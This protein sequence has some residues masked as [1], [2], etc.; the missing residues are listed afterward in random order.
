MVTTE[1]LRLTSVWE[2]NTKRV[3]FSGVPLTKNSYR[4]RSSRAVV[5]VRTNPEN[6]PMQPTVGQH[7]RITGNKEDREVEHGNYI[8]TEYHF[9]NPKRCEVTLP[10]N[11]ED[12]I[13]FISKETAFKGIGEVKARMLWSQ[14]GD[15]IF[16][17]LNNKDSDTLRSILTTEATLSLIE[18][19]EKY[20]NLRY[21]TWFSDHQI[22]PQIQQRLFKFHGTKAVDT[23]KENPYRLI[24]FGLNFEKTDQ[25]AQKH[26]SISR[27][28]KCRLVAAVEYSLQLHCQRGGHTL[29]HHKD[30]APRVRKLLGTAETAKKAF[31]L[32]QSSQVLKLNKKDGV[33]HHT[34]L[35][36]MEKVVAKRLVTL[37][38]QK[39]DWTFDY[40]LAIKKAIDDLPYLLMPKQKQAVSNSLLYSVACITGGA[41]TGKTTVLR[42]VLRAYN[43][44]GYDIRA[45]ALSGRAA[46]HLHK[47]IGFRTSTIARFLADA[48]IEHETKTIVVID[49]ASMIDLAT[50]FRIVN[51]IDPSVRLL[52]VGDHNQLPP[53]GPGLIL[54]DMVK[55]GLIPNVELDIVKRQDATTGI[56]E[57]SR[58]IQQ[59]EIPSQ[60]STGRIH[61]HDVESK[62]VAITCSKLYENNPNHSQVIAATRA[63]SSEIN[64]LCQSAINEDGESL[65]FTEFGNRYITDLKCFDPVL[66]CKNNY[67]AGVQ[68]GSLGTLAS[69]KQTDK[70]FGVVRINDSG[71]DIELTKMLLDSLLLGYA[72]TLHKAQGSQF[73]RVIVALSETSMIDRAWL[74]TAITR[75]E[76][77]LHL[78]GPTY[79]AHKAIKSLSAHHIRKTYLAR[80]LIELAPSSCYNA[81]M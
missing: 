40:E 35:L 64:T 57:Y 9:V 1:D 12:F 55:S 41:G 69:V 56:P 28:D 59:G 72:I 30:I 19:Y 34:M 73:R 44:L 17:L 58:L 22:P 21:A 49:E 81:E 25:I 46:M 23:I 66:F 7:W 24:T 52:F 62:K 71:K 39:A 51:H 61:F 11:G 33:Y 53:I 47:S 18:G 5:V 4:T 20:A 48:P 8:V 2:Y 15:Q 67:E 68:N 37:L 45:V 75:S 63:M 60:L 14:F 3:V 36:L 16:T 80:L 54:A 27:N 31:E 79:R 32:A 38:S 6:L 43:F 76:E 70:H 77:E 65:E 42:T 26:F 74:Y 13:R 50:M 78:V 29:A 10:H